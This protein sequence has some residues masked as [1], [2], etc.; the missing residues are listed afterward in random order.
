MYGQKALSIHDLLGKESKSEAGDFPSASESSSVHVRCTAVTAAKDQASP[1]KLFELAVKGNFKGLCKQIDHFPED[2]DYEADTAEYFLRAVR[3]S[4]IFP[5]LS[6]ILLFMGGLCIAASE[7]YKTR[8]NIIL[9][10]GIFF[11]SA[12]LSNIIG[13]IVY[14]S[15]N[16]GDPS[17]S[18][19]KKNSYSYGW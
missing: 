10:A 11:V 7:F 18:D 15:A 19:S 3:A 9:S 2:A 16:A 14:I 13:I 1:G 8:H 12:G 17:K 6:V 5:I 4:S